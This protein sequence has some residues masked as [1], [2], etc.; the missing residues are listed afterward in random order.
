VSLQ[1]IAPQQAWPLFSVAATRSLEQSLASALPA[2]ALMQRAGLATARLALALAPH[3]QRFWLAC[4]PGNNGGDGL[5]AA[6]HLHRW[7]KTVHVTWLAQTTTAPADARAA[8]TRAQEAGVTFVETPPQLNPEDCAIDALLGIGGGSGSQRAPE[9]ALAACI[10]HLNTHTGIVL[11]VDLPSGL[12]ADTG[13]APGLCVQATHT[14]SLLT[15][16]P[17]LYTAQG[18]DHAGQIWLDTLDD[19]PALLSSASAHTPPHANQSD[20]LTLLGTPSTSARKHASHKG[21]FGD[22]AVIGGAPGMTGAA[23]LAASAALHHGAGRVYVALLDAAAP[24]WDTHRPELMLRHAASLPLAQLTVVAGCGG[25]S[26]IAQEL[27]RI[28]ST[29]PRLVLDA[30][31]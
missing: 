3:A 30:D 6:I 1:A 28:L 13:H 23:L 19:S 17:G 12:N 11:A 4:G 9:G 26:A 31:V 16:K 21:S 29:P 14:L 8:Y 10:E 24:S 20:T 18:R 27:P 5:E 22:V 15:L 7:G 2:H 25:G